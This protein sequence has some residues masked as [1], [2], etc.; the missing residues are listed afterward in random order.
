MP[1]FSC[2][3]PSLVLRKSSDT[4]CCE[5]T[6]V[7]PVIC[8]ISNVTAISSRNFPILCYTMVVPVIFLISLLTPGPS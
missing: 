5:Q 2:L 4:K 3:L 6:R 8:N 7:L 1:G